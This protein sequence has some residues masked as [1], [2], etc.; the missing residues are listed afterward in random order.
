MNNNTDDDLPLVMKGNAWFGSVK[1]AANL[2]EKGIQ[3]IFN[4]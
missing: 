4:V 3:G 2:A 1:S